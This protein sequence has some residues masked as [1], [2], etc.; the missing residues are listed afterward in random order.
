MGLMFAIVLGGITAGLTYFFGY[1]L[2]VMIVL[3]VLWL[4]ALVISA[5]SGHHGFGRRG[6]TDLMIVVAAL[7]IAAAIVVP[8]YSRQ[9]PCNRARSALVSL[10]EAEKE[11]LARHGTYAG[12]I[13]LLDVKQDPGIFV[14]ILRGDKTSFA[15]AA[16]HDKCIQKDGSPR[17]FIW[18]SARGELQ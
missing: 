4:A 2:W 6:N 8:N 16:S 17:M 14:M 13:S 9:T 5:P 7:V 11:Y 18:D 15:A 12:H 3:G 1:S 10:A